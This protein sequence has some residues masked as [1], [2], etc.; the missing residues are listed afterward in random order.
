M[1][2]KTNAEKQ[3][4][5]YNTNLQKYWPTK[6]AH[7]QNQKEKDKKIKKEIGTAPEEWLQ[8]NSLKLYTAKT[9]VILTNFGYVSCNVHRITIWFE[10]KK[11]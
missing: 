9:C 8:S 11:L 6:N 5:N 3:K 7:T 10:T 1:K 2:I 4:T